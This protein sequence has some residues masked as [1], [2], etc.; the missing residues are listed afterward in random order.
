MSTKIE[1][2]IASALGNNSREAEIRQYTYEKPAVQV[3][4]SHVR[5]LFSES[6]F[7]VSY[8]FNFKLCC[9]PNAVT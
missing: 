5:S 7:G 1:M 2:I 8:G 9:I 6:L 4:V 3:G